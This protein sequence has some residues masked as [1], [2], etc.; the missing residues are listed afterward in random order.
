MKESDEEYKK[1]YLLYKELYETKNNQEEFEKKKKEISVG[2]CP[3]CGSI[4]REYMCQEKHLC[5]AFKFCP[6]C[7]KEASLS[8]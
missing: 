1:L 3:I 6:I 8:C 7:G 4:F 2:F 5:T